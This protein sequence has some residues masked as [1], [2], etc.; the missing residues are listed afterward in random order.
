M[1]DVHYHLIFGVDDGPK[2][3]EASLELAEASLA[4][5]VTHVVA[6]PHSS[7]RYPYQR[8]LNEER[9][10]ELQ[11]MMGERL[12]FG[13]GCDFQLS[14]DNLEAFEKEPTRFTINR[15]K[16][17]LVEFPDFVNASIYNDVFF[18]IMTAGVIPIL[19]HPE[20]N[21]TLVEKPD[22]IV[23]WARIGCLVQVTAASLWGRFGR[24]AEALSRALLKGNHVHL[25]ASDAHDVSHRPPAMGQAFQ[26]LKTNFGQE[27]AERL[28]IH[29]P[30]AVFYGEALPV[31]PEPAESIAERKSAYGAFLGRWFR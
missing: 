22:P 23:E 6:T 25:I 24:R 27:T 21:P 28:C 31:Q 12:T 1:F 16:Y 18:R 29:N 4:E 5:G 14:Y 10:Q 8:Q 26:H 20:R 11:A 15:T 30:R 2:S 13:L 7:H 9:L 19:T 3:M 17:L